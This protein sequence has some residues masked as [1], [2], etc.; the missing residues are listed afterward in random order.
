MS[1]FKGFFALY[2][3]QALLK[4]LEYDYKRLEASPMDTYAA[5]DFFITAEHMVDWVYPNDNPTEKKKRETL[6]RKSLLQ[7]CSHIANGSKH[8]E[9]RA[10]HHK[11]VKGTLVRPGA[12]LGTFMLGVSR[13]GTSAGLEI[14]LKGY[15]KRRFGEYI[16]VGHLSKLILD[17]WQ[18]YI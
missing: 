17:F 14:R 18:K 11:S 5:F 16:D 12:Q 6:R 13:L 10:Q 4:K 1:T 9:A 7:I 2:T 8:F 3:P 15:A